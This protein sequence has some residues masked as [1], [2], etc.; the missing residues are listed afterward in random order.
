MARE[1]EVTVALT[2]TEAL[3]LA[4]VADVGLRTAE[5]LSLIQNTVAAET[6]LRKLN[7][8]ASRRG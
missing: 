3:A 2:K 6:A 7:E 4:K 5:A 1:T 8:A